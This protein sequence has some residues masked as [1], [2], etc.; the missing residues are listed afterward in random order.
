MT[1]GFALAILAG[2]CCV[3]YLGYSIWSEMGPT[4][5][6]VTECNGTIARL[7]ACPNCPGPQYQVS[8]KTAS[9][10]VISASEKMAR[11]IAESGAGLGQTLR[12]EYETLWE[13]NRAGKVIGHSRH[14]LI[15]WQ[16]PYPFEI[17][18]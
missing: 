11:E 16:K 17:G 13:K 10:D 6:V 2:I 8:F 3:V 5:T 1:K 18:R 4:T 12:I 15:R 7:V 14:R 9:G